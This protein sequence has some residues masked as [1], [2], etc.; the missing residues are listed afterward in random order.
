MCL[1]RDPVPVLVRAIL[2]TRRLPHLMLNSCSGRAG[3]PAA[4]SSGM[5]GGLGRAGPVGDALGRGEACRDDSAHGRLRGDD[6]AHA[7]E[8]EKARADVG[9]RVVHSDHGNLLRKSCDLCCLEEVT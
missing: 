6:A 1:L 7:R 5:H 3:C 2:E 4:L 8:G 9:V